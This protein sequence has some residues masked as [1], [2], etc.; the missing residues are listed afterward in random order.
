MSGHSVLNAWGEFPV[1][2]DEPCKRYVD[3]AETRQRPCSSWLMPVR[4]VETGS[5]F[6][7]ATAAE[8]WIG[9]QGVARAVRTGA[10]CGGYHWEELGR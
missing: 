9:A 8:R 3:I 1:E 10:T 4:C 6:T 2:D 5:T 7:S